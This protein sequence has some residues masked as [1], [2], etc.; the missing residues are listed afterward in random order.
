MMTAIVLAAGSG[1][2][3]KS[4][5]P[6]QFMR[7]KGRPL[8]ASSLAA[9]Q[10]SPEIDEIILVTSEAYISYCRTEIVEKYGFSKVTHIVPGGKERYDSVW[11]ALLACEG[12]DYV[13]I[14]DS[15]RPFVTG[16]IIARAAEN[17]KKYGT[18]VAGVPSKD[19]IKIANA[20]G[21][22]ETTPDRRHC[23]CIQTPQAFAYPLI[24][25]AN[26]ELRDSGRMDGIT[27]DAMIVER[28]G[29]APVRLFMGS[30]ENIKIT[31]P[32]DLKMLE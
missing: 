20:E 29:L 19:T 13:M 21:F 24:R 17:V 23:W 14:H 15:A 10:D 25:R 11:Q 9:F 3:M 32:D 7:Y 2:R 28:S 12:T 5:V 26:E 30:Y 4:D 18:A 8:A 6:K 22:V 31:T 1:R 27:D 16:E